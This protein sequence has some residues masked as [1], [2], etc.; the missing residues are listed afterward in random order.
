[1]GERWALGVD[2]GGTKLEVARVDGDG[3]VLDD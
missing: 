1:M 2:L 3:K